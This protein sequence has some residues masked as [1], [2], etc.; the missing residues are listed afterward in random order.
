LTFD[1]V[2]AGACNAQLTAAMQTGLLQDVN[3]ALAAAGGSG[4]AIITADAGACTVY[5]VR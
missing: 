1:L 2:F 4:A 3:A 5:K